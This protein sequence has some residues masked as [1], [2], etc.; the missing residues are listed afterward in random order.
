M[1]EVYQDFISLLGAK[2]GNYE[3]FK[4]FESQFEALVPK[5]NAH[6]GDTELPECLTA[7]MLLDGE[8]RI[9]VLAASSPRDATFGPNAATTQFLSAVSYS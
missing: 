6:S 8:Q 2:R 1:N 3:S 7:F 5:F 4:N 9:S